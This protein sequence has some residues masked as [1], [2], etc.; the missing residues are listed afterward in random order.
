VFDN[1]DDPQIKLGEFLPKANYGNVIITSRN[2]HL[3]ALGLIIVEVKDLSPDDGIELLLKHAIKG[4]HSKAEERLIASQIA[5]NYIIL[6]WPLSMQAHIYPSIT[7]LG[8]IWRYLK[9]IIQGCLASPL[10]RA[11]TI[12]IFLFMLHGILAGRS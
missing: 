7:A 8:V 11:L 12:S 2:L 4:C 9:S 1:A 6:H 3:A 5:P 10:L